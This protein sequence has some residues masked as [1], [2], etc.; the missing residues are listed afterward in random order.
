MYNII[1]QFFGVLLVY[2]CILWCFK[3]TEEVIVIIFTAF[4]QLS[5]MVNSWEEQENGEMDVTYFGSNNTI[6]V[7]LIRRNSIADGGYN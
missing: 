7:I 3:L 4:V 2:W 6:N 5:Q 1:Q